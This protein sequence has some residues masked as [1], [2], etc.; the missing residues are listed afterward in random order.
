M[1]DVVT[2][3]IVAIAYVVGLGAL[4]IILL[5]SNWKNMKRAEEDYRAYVRDIVDRHMKER[6]K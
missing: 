6:E 4:G 2:V 5:W 1:M 3:E